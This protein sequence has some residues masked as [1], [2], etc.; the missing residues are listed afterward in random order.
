MQADSVPGR[1]PSV[2]YIAKNQYTSFMLRASG[3]T[4]RFTGRRI[5][6]SLLALLVCASPYANTQQ[7]RIIDERPSSRAHMASQGTIPGRLY[8]PSGTSVILPVDGMLT[9]FNP[10]LA[11]RL[12]RALDSVRILQGVP[13]ASAS[14]LIPDEGIWL[15]A[16]GVSSTYPAVPI[17]PD[18]LFGIGSNTKALV[19]T[20]ILQ[21]A[22]EGLLSL[23]DSLGRWLTPHP[24]ITGSVTIRQLL[25][26]TSGLFDYLNDS[27]KEGDS[28]FANPTRY[29]T[30]EEIITT[31]VGPPHRPPGGPYSY[32]NTDYVLLGMIINRITDSSVSAQLRRRIFA[33]LALDRTFLAAE[34]PLVPP[35][36]DPWDGGADFSAMPITAH[37]SILWTAGGVMSTAENMAR[38]G[39][40]L[41]EGSL[42]SQTSLDQ[43]LSFIPASGGG[44]TGF[45]WTGYGLGVRAG[46]FLGKNVFGHGGQVMGYVSVVAYLP[47]AKAS[48]A[49]LL[50]ASEPDELAFL[51]ALLDAYLKSVVTGPALQGQ[52]YA[53]SG[54][55]DSA[56]TFLV[57]SSN[58][59]LQNIGLYRYG[60]IVS[61]R[62][63]PKSGKVWGLSN[64]LGWELVQIDG[65]TGEA[66]PRAGILLPPGSSTDLK[67]LDFSPGG[68]L[69]LA[70]A[71]GRIYSV[72]TASGVCTL[73][74]S[75]GIPISGIAFDTSGGRLWAAVRANVSLRDRIYRINLQTG[76]TLG[77]GN[78]GFTQPL[79]DIA[80]DGAGNLFGVVRTGT[81]V[82]NNL[83]ARIDTTTGRGTVIGSFGRAGIQS[84]AFS[85]SSLPSDVE[86]DATRGIPARARLQ[87]NFPNPFNPTTTIRYELT[88]AGHVSLKVYDMLGR[89]VATLVDNDEGSGAHSV[90]FDARSS[91]GQRLRLSS[92][93]YTY[94]LL[95]GASAISKKMLLL[96]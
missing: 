17:T 45:N 69:Y 64:A 3:S 85:P 5:C 8:A 18:M 13:G 1:P 47:Q 54:K 84:I 31:F 62:V 91:V 46:S 51:T 63:D 14:V 68:T 38:W 30:P 60:E 57:D 42:L 36:A 29:W 6:R 28:V 79:A 2:D 66:Y 48:F 43:M 74:W 61:A 27:G 76:D 83:L 88:I 89:E 11:S 65:S 86:H 20:T 37:Y 41:Y 82:P 53:F 81:G 78:T 59:A 93:V 77:I 10:V 70:G 40:A 87:Q 24:N 44:T 19:S 25:N 22:D 50:N 15:G 4:S 33:P 7:M 39:K 95:C 49:V 67:G 23:D 72:D 92:G 52:L 80:C 55:S 90:T 16:S 94:R 56:R 34:E 32:C 71:D 75:T 73:V 21:L 9:A 58:G 35:V 12:L 96:K 26:M